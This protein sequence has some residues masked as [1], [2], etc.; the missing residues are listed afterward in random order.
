MR[1][2]GVLAAHRWTRFVHRAAALFLV[3]QHARGLEDVVL[4]MAQ[5]AH[6]LLGVVLGETFLR[7]LVRQAE[8]PAEPLDVA[9]RDLDFGIAAAVSGALQAGVLR[10][11]GNRE[12]LCFS[13][14]ADRGGVS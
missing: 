11:Y 4:A 1:A 8:M 12:R 2:V 7:L 9:R 14:R 10:A 5:Q 3:E 6:F 13:H